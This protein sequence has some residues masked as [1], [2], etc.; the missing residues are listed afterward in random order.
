MTSDD[1][2]GPGLRK[3]RKRRRRQ[4]YYM[5]TAVVLGALIGALLAQPDSE[6]SFFGPDVTGLTLDPMAAIGISALILFSLLIFPLWGFTQI[7][8][9][10]REQNLIGSVGGT[11]AVLN[12]YPVWLMLYAG[13]FVDEPHAFG[14]FLLAFGGTII[15]FL[16]AKARDWLPL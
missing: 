12:G 5:G 15:S 7:D 16:V 6:R 1:Q 11:M 14:L 2:P 10:L 3:T 8:E 9:H 13:G 4:L